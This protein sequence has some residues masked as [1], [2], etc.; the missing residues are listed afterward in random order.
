MNTASGSLLIVDDDQQNRTLLAALLQSA[1]HVTTMAANGR[2]ALEMLQTQ[3]FDLVLLDLLMPEMDGYHVLEHLQADDNLRHIPVIVLAAMD[4]MDSIVRG[5]EMGAADYLPKP[6]PPVLLHTRVIA[7]LEQKHLCDQQ[8]LYLQ[9]LQTLNETP[10]QRVSETMPRLTGSTEVQE[11]Q[12]RAMEA[13]SAISLAL[14]SLMDVDELLTLVMDKSKEVMRA[15]ASSLLMLDQ[16]ASLLRFHVARGTAGEALRSATVTLGHGIAGW[17]AQ[18]GAPLLIPDAYQD[19]R[20]DPSYDKRSGFR[21]RSILTVPLKVKDEVTGVVQVIN[22]VGETAFDQ[23][24]LDLFLSFASQA[25]VALDNARLY[26]R[27]KAMAE[28]LRQALEQERRLTIEKEKM[29]AYIPKQ[30]V[31]E[32]SRNREQKLA[33]GGKNVNLTILFS[34]IQGFTRLSENMASQQVIGFLNT[35]MTAMTTIIEEEGG[36]ID[37]FIGDGIMAVFTPTSED[38][39]H[40]LRAVRAGMRMQKQLY[41]LRQEWATSRPELA[42]MQI[43]VGVNTGEVVSGNIGSETRM[44]YT[45]VGDNVNVASRLESV[46]RAGEVCISESTYRDVEGL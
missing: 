16:A 46:S 44:D 25:S 7:C 36:I 6:F 17:V 27:T 19:P 24:D 8:A 29:G 42:G 23:H 2:Q 26:E 41:S 22:K 18:T 14:T 3:P 37:K 15:E 9:Q 11:Q 30:L 38:D 34:D 43:R 20:F 5:L 12:L 35:Y 32:I 33:L 13:T 21:T 31:D 4:D 39:N 45:V 1:G 40:A 10:A 28:D